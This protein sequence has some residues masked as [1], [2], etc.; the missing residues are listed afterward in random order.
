MAFG[1]GA[2]ESTQ[3]CLE[4]LE[5][6]LRP[7]MIVLDIGTGSGILAEAAGLLG[8]KLVIACDIDPIAVQLARQPLSFIGT[9]N[10]IRTASADLLVANISPEAIIALA[11]EL[12]RVLHK[13][14]MAILS[15][16]ELA[17]VPAVEMALRADGAMVVAS[18]SKGNWSAMT[19]L[20]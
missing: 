16:F 19:V 11:P 13:G 14:G 18:H 3:L 4:A 9:A 20:L 6:E 8:A 2:H 15:G 5:R 12:M 7:D 10:A 17:D 1:T